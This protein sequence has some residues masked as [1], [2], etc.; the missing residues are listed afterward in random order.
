M[1]FT[2][3]KIGEQKNLGKFYYLFKKKYLKL[4]FRNLSN[5]ESKKVMNFGKP[6]PVETVV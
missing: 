1:T 4:D 6:S 2:A 3:A 5:I